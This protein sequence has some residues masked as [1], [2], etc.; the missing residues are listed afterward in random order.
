L[1]LTNNIIKMHQGRIVVNSTV[2]IGT[3]F[4]AYLPV[5]N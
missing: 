3:H 1:P 5:I 2:G 4:I